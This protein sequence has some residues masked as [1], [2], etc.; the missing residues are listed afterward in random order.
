MSADERIPTPFLSFST[1]DET[2]PPEPRAELRDPVQA[3][4][5]RLHEITRENERMFSELVANES[6]L[7][8]LGRSV[9]RVQEEERR[10]LARELHDGLGQTLTALKTQIQ[11]LAGEV[12]E[13][14][15]LRQ[16]LDGC[17]DITVDALR[18]TRELCHLLR[19]RVLDDL[20]LDA[21]LSWLARTLGESTGLEVELSTEGLDDRL[22][23]DL[24]TL[25]FRVVQEALT[26][27]IRHAG[28]DQASVRVEVEGGE[29]RLA[30]R[31]RGKGFDPKLRPERTAG[32]GGFGLDGIR[33]RLEISGGRLKITSSP[34]HGTLV[35]GRTPLP[36]RAGE[37]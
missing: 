25:A 5:E 31:D 7:R 6:R 20:G 35:E 1:S 14:A 37:S 2:R 22:D 26:N 23:P 36:A 21:A 30:V 9:W 24:E 10:R 32:S 18:Q 29:L 12:A 8:T 34:G 11:M 16:R 15:A 33:D 27:V 4:L 19:P 17:V 3:T 28:T 13:E